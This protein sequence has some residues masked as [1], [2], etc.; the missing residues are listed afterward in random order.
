MTMRMKL[1]MMVMVLALTINGAACTRI[2]PGY[3]GIK[4]SMAGDNKGV[5][6][7]PAVTGWVFYNPF[8]TSVLE[9]PT[10]VQTAVWSSNPNEGS[11]NNEEVTF[12]NVDQ[13]QVAVDVSLSYHLQADKVPA[14]YVKYRSDDLNSYTHGLLR[15]AARDAFNEHGG[16]FHIEQIMGDNAEFIQ[17]VRVALQKEVEPVGVVIDQFGIIGIPRPPKAVVDAINAKVH[18]TQLAQQ[19]QNELVQV[20]ADMNKE[21]IKAE[22]YANNALISAEAESTAN[23]KIARSL[24][25]E[26]VEWKKLDKWNGVLPSVTGAGGTMISLSK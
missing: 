25:P 8:L 16:K 11:V 5:D 4:V 26:L 24:T 19:K 18:A 12:S 2:G 9:Y 10:F 6:S 22:T 1:G 20:Q 13:M 15:N 23:L 21:K 14:F 7:T 17:S 3:T